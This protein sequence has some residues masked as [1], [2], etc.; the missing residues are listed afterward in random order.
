M[1]ILPLQYVLFPAPG[2]PS[3]SCANGIF[4][5]KMN[6][7]IRNTEPYYDD[8]SQ[9]GGGVGYYTWRT[10]LLGCC[11]LPILLAYMPQDIMAW[12]NTLYKIGYLLVS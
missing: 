3:T 12:S 4:A 8:G 9:D 6:T 5:V 1:I 11:Y 7:P 2:L 10:E